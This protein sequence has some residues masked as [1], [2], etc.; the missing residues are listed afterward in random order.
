VPGAGD[1]APRWSYAAALSLGD[2]F[3]FG[4]LIPSLAA[5]DGVLA[6]ADARAVVCNLA[7][8]TLGT[9]ATSTTALLAQ[10][11]A[12]AVPPLAG[13]T[14]ALALGKGVYLSARIDFGTV[15]LFS[16]LLQI[17][18]DASPPS[19]RITALVDRDDP[20]R[21]VFTA[22]LP[23]ITLAGTV[24]LTPTDA[25]PGIHLAYRPSAS[26]RFGL[27]GRVKLTGIF[28]SDYSFDVALTVTDAGLTTTLT[29]TSQSIAN[30][31][32]M[33]GIVLS[34]LALELACTWARPADGA[35]PAVP[36]RSRLALAGHV[37]FGPA[38]A[39]DAAD[40]RPSFSAALA[41]V[42][43]SPALAY[44][45]V[46]RDL[47]IGRFLAQCVTGDGGNWPSSFIDVAFLAGT[48]IYYY[49]AAADPA[50]SLAAS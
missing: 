4:A 31:F 27:A 45:A 29:Q 19:V 20:T 28:S 36:R 21:S 14:D 48:R 12:T 34:G 41:L 10:V 25:Y 47:S 50:G 11:D 22:D 17:G 42:G 37:L 49:D 2:G 5:V 30:P 46:D 26:D 3:R 16:R 35:K 7:G 13:L 18:S 32:G 24:L 15:S 38:P 33:P 9:L 43:G 8:E 23:D 39:G 1:A 40:E 6:V 44:V